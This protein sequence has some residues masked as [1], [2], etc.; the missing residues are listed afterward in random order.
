MM[1]ATQLASKEMM[2]DAL[3]HKNIILTGSSSLDLSN[4]IGEPLTGRHFTLTLLPLSQS[5]IV[6]NRFELRTE[7]DNFLIYGSYPE[8]LLE[9]DTEKKKKILKSFYIP[10]KRVIFSSSFKFV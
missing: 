7:L 6:V 3:P 9:P 4:K 8:V 2:I 1:V 5:E 10:T